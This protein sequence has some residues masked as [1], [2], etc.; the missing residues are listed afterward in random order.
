M[1]VLESPLDLLSEL[2]EFLPIR[3]RPVEQVKTTPDE[4]ISEEAESNT[5]RS[6]LHEHRRS[7]Q[8]GYSNHWYKYPS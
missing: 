3:N 1:S 6:H 5:G 2:Q 4:W 7:R 8:Q